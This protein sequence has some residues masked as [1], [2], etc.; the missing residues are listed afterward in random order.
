MSIFS[1][2][3]AVK[4]KRSRHNLSY[5]SK[6]SLGFGDLVPVY[7]EKIVPGDKFK[8]SHEFLMRFSPLA[9]QL[10]QS[11]DCRVDY[12]FVPSR[13]LWKDF[14][15]FLVEDDPTVYPHPCASVAT[16]FNGVDNLTN[17]LVDYYNLPTVNYSGLTPSPVDATGSDRQIDVLPF[18][19]YLKIL[20][21]YY[22]DE[23][24]PFVYQVVDPNTGVTTTDTLSFDDFVE[25]FDAICQTSGT[26]GTE[27]FSVLLQAFS[28][29]H[30]DGSELPQTLDALLKP[31]KCPYPKD[32]FTSA[33]PFAQRGPIVQ[34]PLNGEGDVQVYG[35]TG[36]PK[37]LYQGVGVES[38]Q[39]TTIGPNEQVEVTLFQYG[40]NLGSGS[41]LYDEAGS[42]IS[43]SS[44]GFFESG[45][46]PAEA[47]ENV[48]SS[49]NLSRPITFKAVNVNGTATITDL[50]TAMTVQGWLEKNARAGVRYKEQLY[51]HFGVKSKDYRL[52][53]AE[54]IQRTRSNVTIGEVFST[55]AGT[56][57]ITGL[58]VSTATGSSVSK[59]FKHYFDEH[60]YLIGLMSV[61]PK[62][63][64]SQGIPRQFME[65]DKFDY[66]WP[67]FQNIGEQDIQSDELFVNS[68]NPTV[69][70]YTPRYAQYKSRMNQIHG[71]F[72]TTMPF[73]TAS[74]IF[75]NKPEL[76]RPFISVLPSENNLNRIFN[77]S[78]PY[79][80][81]NSQPIYI[82]LFHA[83]NAL[84][85]MQYFGNPR[86]I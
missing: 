37:T 64:Y 51:S 80:P 78:A 55:S 71:D 53:R 14:E 54:L 19:A 83:V 62:A 49:H 67:E 81:N 12:F 63:G 56:N 42:P 66:Y 32:Y 1:K 86:I 43:Q 5:A 15:K 47:A 22:L 50:R 61:F 52:D 35:W 38:K 26:G 36:F 48:H 69:F 27:Y 13:L 79:N 84:R 58:G 77:S 40:H 7:C 33:L 34:I 20:I 73:M 11:F 16:L 24:L 39:T 17:T 82:D 85:P 76:N 72:R 65:L 8:H 75:Q 10:F 6:L 23:N 68:A 57:Q 60:G 31:F 30:A 28:F 44:G 21:D 4:P 46:T 45:D 74:R 25:F 41:G 18:A 3:P 59:P 2:I 29:I 70:G 9:G